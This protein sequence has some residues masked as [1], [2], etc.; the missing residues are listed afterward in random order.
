MSLF[1]QPFVLPVTV[2][3][4]IDAKPLTNSEVP[5]YQVTRE[6]QLLTGS[7]SETGLC[8]PKGQ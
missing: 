6:F 8:T 4:E 7:P 1:E 5:P 2:V 3:I